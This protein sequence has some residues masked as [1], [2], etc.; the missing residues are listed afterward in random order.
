[1][2]RL[3]LAS[4]LAV[5]AAAQALGKATKGC[6]MLGRLGC[7]YVPAALADKESAT[8]V[9]YHRGHWGDYK[10]E[11]PEDQRSASA[12]QAFRRYGL[13]DTADAKEAVLFVTASSDLSVSQRSIQRIK[14]KA[15]LDF[16]KIIL[17]SHSG[18]FTGLNATLSGFDSVDGVV[19]LDTNYFGEA[20]TLKIKGKLRSDSLCAGF[21][22]SKNGTNI[23]HNKEKYDLYFKPHLDE[24]ACLMEQ[25]DGWGHTGGVV[26]CFSYYLDGQACPPKP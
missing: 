24:K 16:A 7:V 2:R 14:T 6:E 20:M 1:M 26:E 11:V 13:K 21:Y 10:G 17:A 9:I 4:L 15:G 3:L 18:G 25:H 8:L 5:P 19:L 22:T 23:G 12:R